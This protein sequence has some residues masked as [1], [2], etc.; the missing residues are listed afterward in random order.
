MYRKRRKKWADFYTYFSRGMY[1]VLVKVQIYLILSQTIGLYT[2]VI[3]SDLVTT[4]GWC[5]PHSNL[6]ALFSNVS[7]GHAYEVTHKQC[8]KAYAYCPFLFAFVILSTVQMYSLIYCFKQSPTFERTK[9]NLQTAK[10]WGWAW[11]HR[12]MLLIPW[13]TF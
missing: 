7:L 10:N 8:Q 12:T 2:S 5:A 11:Q 9:L 4:C 1:I 6:W 3:L 13:C